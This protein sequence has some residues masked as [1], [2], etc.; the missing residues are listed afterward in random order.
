MKSNYSLP[1]G[2]SKQYRE[3]MNCKW[4]VQD[5]IRANAK[6]NKTVNG[7]SDAYIPDWDLPKVIKFKEITT[8]CNWNGN[9]H[10]ERGSYKQKISQSSFG[11]VFVDPSHRIIHP[12]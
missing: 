3:R 10:V 7:I 2:G 6:P 4:C 8:G 9:N 5:R 12:P 11:F 1:S